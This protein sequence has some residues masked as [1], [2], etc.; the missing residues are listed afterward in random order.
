VYLQDL[1]EQCT[2]NL[3]TDNSNWRSVLLMIPVRLGGERF[4]SLYS[5]YVKELLSLPHCLGIIGGK[6]RHSLYFVGFQ[7]DKLI[8]M[9]PHYCQR[10][11]DV[12]EA[13]FPLDTYHC[14]TPRK[15]DLREID[16]SCAFGFYFSSRHQLDE[17]VEFY[18]QLLERTRHAGDYP[19]FVLNHG[20]NFQDES[21][22]AM[23]EK[24][25]RMN[26]VLVDSKGNVQKVINS[27]EFVLL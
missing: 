20:K 23:P 5:S 27:E 14:L 11:V 17:F 8:F 16:P 19:I 25:L 21:E 22:E 3:E 7:N 2:D 1:I 13:N 15:C 24:V 6:P 10:C 26:R 12:T 4:N 18:E 9:D